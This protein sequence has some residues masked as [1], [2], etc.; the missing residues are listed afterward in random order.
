MINRH[1]PLP[2]EKKPFILSNGFALNVSL[3]DASVQEKVSDGL[4]SVGE[5]G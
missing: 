1:F 2:I 3:E 5:F 4:G